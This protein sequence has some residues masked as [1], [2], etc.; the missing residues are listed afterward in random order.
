[1]EKR[2]SL[3]VIIPMFNEEAGAEVCVRTV[4]DELKR[5]PVISKLIVIDDGS[6]DSTL[7][8]LNSCAT[9]EATLV[10]ESHNRN[11]GYGAA[12]RTGVKQ[13]AE[14]GMDYSLFMDSD[15][16]NSPSDIAVFLPMIAAGF[17]VIKATRYSRG[18]GVSGVPLYRFLIS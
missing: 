17:D 14:L 15:L 7:Q 13:S 3:A 6:T 12:L 18:G 11:R 5:L 1:M 8:I 9:K 2:H 10:V 4:C 16:T